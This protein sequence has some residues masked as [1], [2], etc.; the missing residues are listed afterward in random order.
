MGNTELSVGQT[1]TD[2]FELLREESRS[3]VPTVRGEN[4][5]VMMHIS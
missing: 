3:A 2:W 1:L 4:G 5:L